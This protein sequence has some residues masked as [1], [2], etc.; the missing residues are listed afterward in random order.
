[1]LP[2]T[3]TL[4]VAGAVP[5]DFDGTPQSCQAAN[6]DVQLVAYVVDEAGNPVNVRNASALALLLQ[7]P[8]GTTRKLAATLLTSGLDGALAYTLGAAD[9][10]QA[11]LYRLQAAYTITGKA[12]TTRWGTFRAEANIKT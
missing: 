1:M 6:D 2:L 5:G 3:F 10:P 11:G 8:D 12:Q 4:R 7:R 9:L